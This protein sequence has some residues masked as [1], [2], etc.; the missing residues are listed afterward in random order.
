LN[1]NQ[2]GV[3]N[4]ILDKIGTRTSLAFD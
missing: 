2:K 1:L 3:Y 4:F